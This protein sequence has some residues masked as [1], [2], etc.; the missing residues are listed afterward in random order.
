MQQKTDNCE[1]CHETPAVYV[2]LCTGIILCKKCLAP[3]FKSAEIVDHTFG[4]I[5]NLEIQNMLTVKRFRLETLKRELTSIA[6]FKE[7]CE[8]LIKRKI[9][10]FMLDLF[11]Q[12]DEVKAK[13]NEACEEKS[14]EIEKA[15]KFIE[16]SPPN[17]KQATEIFNMLELSQTDSSKFDPFNMRFDFDD[18]PKINIGNYYKLSLQWKPLCYTGPSDYIRV[19]S[20]QISDDMKEL[21]LKENSENVLELGEIKKKDAEHLN[22][23]FKLFPN[24][25]SIKFRKQKKRTL[26]KFGESF[27]NLKKLEEI[28]ISGAFDNKANDLGSFFKGIRNLEKVSI[29]RLE[30]GA[31]LDS[32]SQSLSQALL[33]FS[34]LKELS[35]SHSLLSINTL[36]QLSEVFPK[37]LCLE[38]LNLNDTGITMNNIRNISPQF[39]SL[40]SLKTL[41][42]SNNNIGEQ[43]SVQLTRDIAYLRKLERLDLQNTRISSPGAAHLSSIWK[44]LEGLKVLLLSGNLIN[45]QACQ[46]LS[47]GISEIRSLEYLDLSNNLIKTQGAIIFAPVLKSL[48]NL[49]IL[50]LSYNEIKTAGL[51]GIL[52]N[53]E[54]NKE[55]QAIKLKGNC[56]NF[57][58]GDH[59]KTLMEKFEYLNDLDLS[60]NQLGVEGIR[61]I[62]AHISENIEILNLSWNSIGEEGI[63]HLV[64]A[65][66]QL[67]SLRQLHLAGNLIGASG[68][69]ALAPCLSS[70]MNLQILDLSYNDI[71]N[72]F[73]TIFGSVACLYQLEELD[74]SH[75]LM[76]KQEA[77]EM[78]KIMPY[79]KSLKIFRIGNNKLGSGG[80]KIITKSLESLSNLKVIDLSFNNINSE[81]LASISSL[82]QNISDLSEFYVQGNH[83]FKD[84][85]YE[86]VMKFFNIIA[87]NR[88]LEALDISCNDLNV[89]IDL[90]KLPTKLDVL[91]LGNGGLFSEGLDLSSIELSRD[92]ISQLKLDMLNSLDLSS[93]KIGAVEAAKF[94]DF[95]YL[96]Y[97]KSINLSSNPLGSLGI[98][99][100]CQFVQLQTNLKVLLLRNIQMGSDGA[101]ELGKTLFKLQGLE[102]LDISCNYLSS[103]GTENIVS[104]LSSLQMLQKLNFSKNQLGISGSQILSNALIKLNSLRVLDLGNNGI[105]AQGLKELSKPLA[106]MPKLAELI[107][108]GNKL[109]IQ[110]SQQL[111]IVLRFMPALKVLNLRW[112]FIG[113]EGARH[114]ASSLQYVS[115]LKVL[116]LGWNVLE[117]E[118]IKSLSAAISILTDL[119]SLSLSRG[120][121]TG[122]GARSF[123]RMLSTLSSLEELD[124]SWNSLGEDGIL[125]V[126]QSLNSLPQLK[127][128]NIMGNSLKSAGLQRFFDTSP[129]MPQL[130]TLDISYNNIE[131]EGADLFIQNREKFSKIKRIAMKGNNLSN[132]CVERL[133][134][135]LSTFSAISID[136]EDMKV[137]ARVADIENIQEEELRISESIASVSY[138]D[139]TM[140][141]ASMRSSLDKL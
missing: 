19:Y 92:L 23:Y 104:G 85:K 74:I 134:S 76:R 78:Q 17:H 22:Y 48:K 118:G 2:C 58:A 53:F 72:G 47:N 32:E 121:I 67:S 40:I 119:K 88:S 75:N 98:S 80:I 24:I 100:L 95:G 122:F 70:I 97:L 62:S 30:V 29:L 87:N 6:I 130:Q 20:H 57:E 60:Q 7:D 125:Q 89:G 35:F 137:D 21:L 4:P 120:Q 108:N 8:D 90:N 55:I 93:C 61:L 27:E 109:R 110:G 127:N 52:N 36:T 41:I 102:M 46:A 68:M 10:N 3:H 1:S 94:I 66:P 9:D 83:L 11:D 133:T 105:E 123:S 51:L 106:K 84:L 49:K 96:P 56:L 99:I 77:K 59:V 31:I 38:I 44:T 12:I 131:D 91:K 126:A 5:D 18:L 73:K 63:G 43:G 54:E 139:F 111:S 64:S 14:K 82:I 69:K 15:I 50:D 132:S 129:A 13:L 103:I 135:C 128:L 33:N 28:S 112:N 34:D 16:E 42:L 79:F 113:Y 140:S 124:I 117:D 141:Q 45:Y 71:G 81:G 136:T 26:C 65:L 116:D 115:A 25:Q 114:I 86:K 37:L 138:Y 101:L 107:L 39:R